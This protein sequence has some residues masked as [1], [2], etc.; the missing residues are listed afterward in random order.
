MKTEP[1]T[2]L[3]AVDQPQLVRICE[4]GE[5]LGPLQPNLEF[6]DEF[7]NWKPSGIT[8]GRVSHS[9]VGMYREIL[10]PN[11]PGMARRPNDGGTAQSQQGIE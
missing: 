7:G 2:P 8:T 5:D 11:A 3:A 1:T 10:K 9:M 6:Q 4:L